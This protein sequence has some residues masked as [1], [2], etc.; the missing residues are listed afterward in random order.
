MQTGKRLFNAFSIP[1]VFAIW[2]SRMTHWRTL[3]KV[4][5]KPFE[6]GQ[7]QDIFSYKK[8]FTFRRY[9]LY[10][11]GF[12]TGVRRCT[13]VTNLD[14]LLVAQ[15]NG[16]PLRKL[17]VKIDHEKKMVYRLW[18]RQESFAYQ[19]Y[20]PNVENAFWTSRKTINTLQQL[21]TDI[22]TPNRRI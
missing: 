15:N 21:D 5:R 10:N 20:G 19:P 17:I 3:H 4:F 14:Q 11:G 18:T 1:E 9:G 12:R 2:L 6:G 16:T 22:T 13:V 7:P 8:I